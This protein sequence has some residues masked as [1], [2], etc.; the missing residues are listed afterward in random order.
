[1]GKPFFKISTALM[2]IS[3]LTMIGLAEP[4][5]ARGVELSQTPLDIHVDAPPPGVMIIW[6]N[7]ESMDWEFVT[8]EHM[9]LFGDCHYLFPDS[10][11]LP[12][13]TF[14]GAGSNALN[15]RQRHMWR[16]RWSGYN[17]LYYR[18]DRSYMPWPQ[19]GRFDFHDAHLHRPLSKPVDRGDDGVRFKMADVFFTVRCNGNLWPIPNA[20]YF[21]LNDV[22]GNGVRDRNDSIYLVAWQDADGDGRLDVSGDLGNDQRCYFRFADDGDHIVEDGELSLVSSETEKN[23][24]RPKVADGEGRALRLQTDREELQNFANWFSYHRKR[25]FVSKSAVAHAIVN[26]ERI[27]IGL[28]AV[29]GSPRLEVLPVKVGVPEEEETEHGAI[30]DH[31]ERLLDALYAAPCG[32]RAA[33]REALYNVGRYFMPGENSDLGPSPYQA[34]EQGSSCLRSHVLIVAGGYWDDTSRRGGNADGD[35]GPPFADRWPDTLA[36][37]AMVL[38]DRDLAP[39]LEDLLSANGCDE[40]PHQHI[41]TH[42]VWIGGPGVLDL[43]RLL[44]NCD[45]QAGCRGGGP[46]LEERLSRAPAW[47]QPIPG[48]A[49]TVDDLFHAAVNGR[50]FHFRDDHHGGLEGAVGQVMAFVARQS[51][52]Y[53]NEHHGPQVVHDGGVYKASYHSDDWSGELHAFDYDPQS[54]QVGELRWRAAAGLDIADADHDTRRI[55]TFGGIWRRPQGVPFR[56]DDLSA[57]QK[58]ALGSDL[59]N[60][61]TADDDAIRV[62]NYIRGLEVPGLRLRSTLLGDIV[63]SVPVIE[64]ETLFVGSNDGMLHA[65]DIAS[66]RERFAYVP[67]LVLGRLKELVVPGYRSNHRFYVDG[68][69]YAGEVLEGLYQRKTYLV[70]GLGKGGRGYYCLVI[71]ARQRDPSGAQFGAYRQTFT[72]DDFGTGT[73]EQE[74]SRIV[75]WEYPPPDVSDDGADNDHDGLQDEQ[76]ETDP[77]IGYSL[78]KAYV[79]NANAPDETYRSVVIFGNGY[80]SANGKAVLYIMRAA[81]GMLVRKIDTGA[82][83][84]N[85]LSV[86]ALIDVNGD[87]LVDYAYAGDLQG[88]LWK[89]DLRDERPDRWGI[90]YGADVDGD[91]VIDASRGDIPTPLFQAQGQP[92]TARPDVMAMMNACAPQLPGYMIIFGTGRYLGIADR[93]ETRPQSV[94]GIW[95]YGEDGDDSESVGTLST[96]DRTS[97]RL[98]GGLMLHPITVA[99]EFSRSGEVYRR[100]SEW[101]PDFRTI[102]DTEDGDGV[103]AN[104]DRCEKQLNPERYAGWIFNLPETNGSQRQPAERIV[105]DVTIRGGSAVVTSYQPSDAY[106]ESGG[107]SWLYVLNGCGEGAVSD[108]NDGETLLP[109]VHPSRLHANVIIVKKGLTS[110]LDHILIG[111]HQGRLVQRAFPGERWGRVFWRQCAEQ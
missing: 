89:F 111:D 27:R 49:S 39:G 83:G 81:D 8:D 73:S 67:N 7:S 96:A 4:F 59:K 32:G 40:A 11:Y 5:S 86:P 93:R 44:T 71:G 43:E 65:F 19:T 22:N 42:T 88:N 101:V 55:V 33:L 26:A 54:G 3:C 16:S 77:D 46:C 79:L 68:S 63:N 100:L 24:I 29:N 106:C 45:F 51:A 60:G 98:S 9:G 2:Y 78:G 87:R 99:D 85:G 50:G 13:R 56:Y 18:P 94:Y 64:G 10:A 15:D 97:G 14:R 48:H 38:Y 62:L 74:V 69:P 110:Q 82:G 84:D 6:D 37:I 31:S 21:T 25:S 91:G 12:R 90:A 58:G 104:N 109:K 53:G 36:D 105:S 20:H 72:V 95:D 23:G 102:E 28:Y 107:S 52:W 103:S 66:G 1:M 35:Q 17:R 70:G 30:R 61:S 57:G 75:V 34:G 80:N 41:V 76:D 92:I 47:P 108:W